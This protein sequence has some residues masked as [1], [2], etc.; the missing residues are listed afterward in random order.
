M[1]SISIKKLGEPGGNFPNYFLKVIVFSQLYR[2]KP[3]TLD[4][5][6]D[7]KNIFL[8]MYYLIYPETT[9]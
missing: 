1:G 9:E 2:S 3:A 7:M 8:V 4:I 6:Y 5:A